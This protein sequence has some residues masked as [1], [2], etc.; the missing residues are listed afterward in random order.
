MK[1]KMHAVKRSRSE[2]LSPE[3]GYG[4]Q[5]RHSQVL[6]GRGGLPERDPIGLNYERW[7]RRQQA[8]KAEKGGPSSDNG[9]IW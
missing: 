3:W 2:A 4:F 9:I 6:G 1:P 8:G 5:K 7:L